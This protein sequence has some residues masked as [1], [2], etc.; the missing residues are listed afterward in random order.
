MYALL[1][2]RPLLARPLVDDRP[3]EPLCQRLD[4]LR[5]SRR[6]QTLD[7][8]ANVGFIYVQLLCFHFVLPRLPDLCSPTNG[9]TPLYHR[10]RGV[11]HVASK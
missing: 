11:V 9:S 3:N 1:D 4:A 10:Q 6:D 5:R 2:K 7:D 8:L